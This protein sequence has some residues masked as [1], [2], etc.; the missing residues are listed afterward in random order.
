M[1]GDHSV[2]GQPRCTLYSAQCPL[3]IAPYRSAS[4]A[5][6]HAMVAMARISRISGR[7]SGHPPFFQASAT[8]ILA[9]R[10]AWHPTNI[11]NVDMAIVGR[12]VG[13]RVSINH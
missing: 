10:D 5:L 6:A 9:E 13:R 8:A 7:I 4:A 1:H 3:I 2:R 11:R 12:V